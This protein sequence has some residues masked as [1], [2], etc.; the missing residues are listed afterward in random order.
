MSFDLDDRSVEASAPREGVEF[1]LP[2]VTYRLTP[3]V[4]DIVINGASYKAGTIQRADLRP[5]TADES[6]G[7]LEITML[8]SHAVPQ[9]Y[10]Q[11]GVP[12]REIMVNVYSR[13]ASGEYEPVWT[14]TV[15]GMR[16]EGH[17][18]KVLVSQRLSDAKPRRIPTITV[19]RECPHILYDGNCKINRN[20]FK[21]ATTLTYVDGRSLQI[22]SIG[23]HPD[24]WALFGELLHVASGERMTVTRQ[25]GVIVEIQLPIAGMQ[26]GD[27][28][29]I[30]AGC[31]HTLATCVDKFDNRDN[32]GGFPLLPKQNPFID[33]GYGTV[34]QE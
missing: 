14:G 13:Q 22:A 24:S 17:L 6:P 25:E 15:V 34:E 23:G 32:Y 9:R 8:V 3:A 12:P 5:T 2:A 26:A 10:L 33:N 1:V 4:T 19:G 30:Y 28:I 31:D 21:V 29:E 18:A 16:C 27:A 20:A 11:L 7:E